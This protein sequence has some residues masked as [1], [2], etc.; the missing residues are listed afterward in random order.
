MKVL[1][2]SKKDAYPFLNALDLSDDVKRRVSLLL[3]RTELGNNEIFYTPLGSE[4]KADIILHETD[5]LFKENSDL[6]NSTLADLERN[7]RDKF[8]PRSI[9]VPWPNRKDK[10][11][12]SF[13]PF[14]RSDKLDIPKPTIP[15]SRLRPISISQAIKLLKNDTNSGLPYYTRKSNVKESISQNFESLLERKDPCLLFTRTQEDSKTRNVW[16]YPIADTLNEM[17]YYVPILDYQRNKAYRAALLGPDEVGKS[18]CELV[19]KAQSEARTLVSIDFTAYDDSV[20]RYLHKSAFDYIKSLYQPKFG[21]ELDY[22]SSRFS[23]IGIVTPD[24]VINGNHGV[25][26]GS[27][28]TNEVDSIV[29]MLIGIQLPFISVDSMLIQGDDGVYIIPNGKEEV[30]FDHFSKF[31]LSVNRDKSYVSK[32]YVTF[33]QCLYHIDYINK[34]I[35]GG[36]YPIYRA[37]NRLCYQERWSDFEDF[38]VSGKD[39]YSIR[40]L[41]ILENCKWHPL[42]EKFVKLVLSKDKYSLDFSSQG[43]SNY[44][45]MVEKIKG[46]EGILINQYG[47][48]V[49]GLRSFESYKL[50]RKLS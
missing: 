46:T 27:T 35:V 41:C 29:Q 21:D 38:G 18:T 26:S 20:K 28:F 6:I 47:D 14:E 9:A 16:G 10:L 19:L 30:V 24:G 11:L 48:N 7:N 1:E 40:A 22:I 13:K 44:V 15:E 12:E 37:L 23:S 36:I 34:G 45:H 42:F 4:G 39:Y 31:G 17:M 2:I 33:L 50:I 25:P 3:R 49:S 8:G 32:D 43:L 5:K